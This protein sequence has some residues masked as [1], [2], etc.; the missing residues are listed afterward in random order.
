M[1]PIRPRSRVKSARG[2]WAAGSNHAPLTQERKPN[3]TTIK[4]E[5][6][7]IGDVIL[8]PERELR[9]WMRRHV[10]EKGLSDEALNLTV[11]EIKPGRADKR[12]PW[13]VIKTLHATEWGETARF[14]FS[15][16]VRPRTD[17]PIINPQIALGGVCSECGAQN[18]IVNQCRCDP[19]NLPT[20]A[21][22][23]NQ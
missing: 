13:L 2:Q 21:E 14:P 9:L 11:T 3:M 6:I 23:N 17:W 12:G 20:R 22:G 5:Q 18:A 1:F 8:P 4:A 19:N 15:F 7:K 10:R 16:T